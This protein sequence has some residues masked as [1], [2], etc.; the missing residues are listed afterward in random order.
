MA[1]PTQADGDFN[2]DGA[3]NVA[4]LDYMFAQYGLDLAVVS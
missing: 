3:I 2:G 4:D 1:N